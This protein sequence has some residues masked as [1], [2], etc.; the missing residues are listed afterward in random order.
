MNKEI[1]NK[2]KNKTIETV[3]LDLGGS[4]SPN[5]GAPTSKYIAP[6]QH[7]NSF[8]ESANDSNQKEKTTYVALAKKKT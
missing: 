7:N 6:N 4:R 8:N 2:I 3:K 5:C 1:K